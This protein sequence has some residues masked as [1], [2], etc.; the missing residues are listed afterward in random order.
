[1]WYAKRLSDGKEF[2]AT[3]IYV[4]KTTGVSGVNGV[5]SDGEKVELE[6]GTFDFYRR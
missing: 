3:S 4:Y 1:M 6:D 5:A 2:L